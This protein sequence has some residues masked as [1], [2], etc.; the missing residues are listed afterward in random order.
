MSFS[1]GCA[2]PAIDY[3]FGGRCPPDV[4]AAL[5]G[6]KTVKDALNNLPKLVILTK[7]AARQLGWKL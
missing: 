4:R 5:S 1:V 3:T 6:I 2:P 7:S